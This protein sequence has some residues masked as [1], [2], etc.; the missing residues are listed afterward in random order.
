QFLKATGVAVTL[1]ALGTPGAEGAD[2][3]EK[4]KELV[5]V[6]QSD[7]SLFEK[8][9]ACQQLGEIGTPEAIPALAALLTDPKLTAYARSGLE[10]SPAPSAAATLRDA[11]RNLTG[12]LLAGVVN[13]L[14]VLR[15]SQAI[16]ILTRL[17]R[18]PAGGVSKEALLALG[19]IGTPEAVGV[20]EET[21]K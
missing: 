2:V 5:A 6:L 10:A 7:A 14:G 4:T 11:A 18:E 15:D 19:N 3:A 21:L 1:L 9:R 17:V 16:Q 8:A 20:V 13:S 12:P